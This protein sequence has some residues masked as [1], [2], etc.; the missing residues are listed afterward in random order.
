MFRWSATFYVQTFGCVV[1]AA[2]VFAFCNL[3]VNT[4]LSM[5]FGEKSKLKL[6]GKY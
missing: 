5:A 3:L 1:P 6:G 4:A 2:F